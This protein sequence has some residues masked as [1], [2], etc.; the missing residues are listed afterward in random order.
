MK[1]T[2]RQRELSLL[3]EI[4]TRP[5]AQFL[6]LYGRRRIGKTSLL[7]H[8]LK[9]LKGRSLFWSATQTSTR[10]QLRHFSQALFAFLYPDS[11][12]DP[13]FQYESWEAAFSELARLKDSHP[14][15]SGSPMW[16]KIHC[17]TFWRSSTARCQSVLFSVGGPA[18]KDGPKRS[19]IGP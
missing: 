9:P 2:G 17:L 11:Q 7:A 14:S 8:W 1:F 5:G 6:V 12:V 10:N 3:N 15:R 16:C 19:R 18:E 13:G 4:Y